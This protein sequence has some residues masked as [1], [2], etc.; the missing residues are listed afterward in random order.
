[1]IITP[2]IKNMK[3]CKNCN[4]SIPD[5]GYGFCN[6]RCEHEYKPRTTK[7]FDDQA[8]FNL[9]AST[10]EHMFFHPYDHDK[11]EIEQNIKFLKSPIIA[12]FCDCSHNFTQEKLL[13]QY[14]F[15]SSEFRRYLQEEQQRNGI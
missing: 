6:E 1:V 5:N 9:I 4:K 12:S 15:K 14:L 8:C 10:I 7:D 11:K 13:K 3:H 2:V